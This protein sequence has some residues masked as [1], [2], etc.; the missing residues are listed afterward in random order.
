MNKATPPSF[1]EKL[2][3]QRNCINIS[4]LNADLLHL[5]SGSDNKSL[6]SQKCIGNHKKCVTSHRAIN[7]VEKMEAVCSIKM[8]PS[9]KAKML[10]DHFWI[11]GWLYIQLFYGRWELLFDIFMPFMPKL[12]ING[13]AATFATIQIFGAPHHWCMI[14]I[15][16]SHKNFIWALLP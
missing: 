16:D 4:L 14:E 12:A 2:M 11:C 9:N 8:Q 3:L 15:H 1:S 13:R 5:W 10:R 7:P 6:H